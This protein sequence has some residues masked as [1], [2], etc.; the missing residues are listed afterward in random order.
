MAAKMS[1]SKKKSGVQRLATGEKP[2]LEFARAAKLSVWC[3]WLAFGGVLLVCIAWVAAH[4]FFVDAVTVRLCKEADENIPIEKRMPVFLGESAFDGYA[5]NYHAEHLGEDGGWRLRHTDFDNAPEGRGVH[6]NSAFAWYLRGLG[7]IYREK[8]GE[9]LRNSI[10]RMSIWANS[11]VL[12][13][14][15]GMFGVMAA[16]RFGPLCGVVIVLGMIT[17]ETFYE[18][19]MPAYPDH[20]GLIAAA[21]LG[22]LLGI[23]LAGAGWIQP[24]DGMD[25]ALPTSQ[26]QARNG[27]LFS[28]ICGAAGMWISA[29]SMAVIL[30]A[31]GVSAI[32]VLF[33]RGRSLRADGCEFHGSLWK[34]WAM[35]G[36]GCSLLFYLLEY[37]PFNMGMR[38]EVNHPLYSLAWLGGGWTIAAVGDWRVGAKTNPFP[39]KQLLLPLMA[40]SALPAVSVFGGVAVYI[41]CDAFLARL[42][43][44]IT[45][46]LPLAVRMAR[47]LSWQ[48]AFGYFPVFILAAAALQFSRRVGGGAKFLMLFLVCPILLITCLEFYQVRWGM[49]VGPAYIV[50]AGIVVPLAWR[51]V[52]RNMRWGAFPSLFALGFLFVEPA[53]IRSPLAPSSQFSSRESHPFDFGQFNGLLHRQMAQAIRDSDGGRPVVLLSSP[54]SSCMLAA[55]G[56][57]RTVG[58]LYWENVDGLKAAAAGLNAQ[59]DDAAFA[60]MRKHGVTHISLMT[61]EN[62]N[63]PF[64]RILYPTPPSGVSFA[65]S[66]GGRALSGEHIP[67]WAKRIPLRTSVF[68]N[69]L[70]QDV[71]LLRVEP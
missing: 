9:T 58:T 68:A 32:V 12:V 21:I 60:F 18:G 50:L 40:V 7:E 63:K 22:I 70:K 56:G 45:E 13:V 69:A 53:F 24:A 28:A 1:K 46:L 3:S 71:V 54:N 44:H 34:R 65:K 59:G 15:L 39:W 62:F 35:W 11:C 38:L 48:N 5:W 49:L 25:F 36:A 51:F 64:F 37:A 31:V 27:M 16:K 33:F 20:H 30:C 47:G 17:V 2:L 57:F 6:W 8:T 52:P 55:L 10:F 14:M 41:P 61:W 26:R 4:A 43:P 66:F 67:L 42:W 29:L 23:V 19:F